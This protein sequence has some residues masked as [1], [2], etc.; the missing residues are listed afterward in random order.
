MYQIICS[1]HDENM[2][3]LFCLKFGDIGNFET[4]E[5]IWKR[6]AS[7]NDEDP[8]NKFWI[9]WIWVNMRQSN[10]LWTHPT[11]LKHH[12]MIVIQNV[13]LVRMQRYSGPIHHVKCQA[14]AHPPDNNDLSNL[15]SITST[16]Q[17]FGLERLQCGAHWVPMQHMRGRSN[18]AED[19]IWS[20]GNFASPKK[21]EYVQIII[22]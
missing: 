22:E 3:T 2:D 10:D 6:R 12:E 18:F 21:S 8:L 5:Q 20:F 1:K 7:T 13:S 9:S 16:G 17:T 4:L 11:F 15:R 14:S 19:M